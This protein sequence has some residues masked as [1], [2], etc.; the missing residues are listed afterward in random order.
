VIKRELQSWSSVNAGP[1]ISQVERKRLRNVKATNIIR[2][3]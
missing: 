2:S 1:K 3:E